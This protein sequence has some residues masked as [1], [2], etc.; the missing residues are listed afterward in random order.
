MLIM[1]GIEH[2]GH[3]GQPRPRLNPLQRLP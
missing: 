1:G 2:L 3:A